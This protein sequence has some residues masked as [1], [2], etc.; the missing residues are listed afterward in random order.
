MVAT[1]EHSENGVMAASFQL[2]DDLQGF[3]RE[4]GE[5]IRTAVQLDSGAVTLDARNRSQTFRSDAAPAR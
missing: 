2:T 4:Q 5:R 1:V 3:T